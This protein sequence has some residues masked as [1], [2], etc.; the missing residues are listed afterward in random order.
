[1]RAENSAGQIETNKNSFSQ[2]NLM[3]RQYVILAIGAFLLFGIFFF[4]KQPDF[5]GFI[6]AQGGNVT[7]VNIYSYPDVPWK[8]LHGLMSTIGVL[9]VY[10]QETDPAIRLENIGLSPCT[11]SELYST[12]LSTVNWALVEPA[13]PSDVDLFLG[14]ANTS[15]YSGTAIFTNLSAFNVTNRG[16]LLYSTRTVSQSGVYDLGILKQG[17]TL[18]FVSH[19]DTGLA[20]DGTPTDYQLMLPTPSGLNFTYFLFDDPWDRTQCNISTAGNSGPQFSGLGNIDTYIG[21]ET[22]GTFYATDADLDALELV[23]EPDMNLGTYMWYNTVLGRYVIYYNFT[24]NPEGLFSVNFVLSDGISQTWQNIEVDVGYCGNMDSGGDPKCESRFEDCE[25]CPRDC[26]L[27]RDNRES[28]ALIPDQLFCIGQEI[29]FT[30]YERYKPDICHESTYQ[31]VGICEKLGGVNVDILVLNRGRWKYL[32]SKTTAS[33]G[34]FTF[35]P[36]FTR[37]Y[38]MI[39]NRAGHYPFFLYLDGLDCPIKEIPAVPPTGSIVKNISETPRIETP[40]PADRFI[41]S[42]P[43]LILYNLVLVGVTVFILRYLHK[44]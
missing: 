24:G 14:V 22:S 16:Y 28:F 37:E 18:I 15:I 26:G 17:G 9:S 27:C 10:L 29:T 39:A 42:V 20:Y 43:L 1:M 8:G 21:R 30:A 32:E 19:P 23:I 4:L 41:V 13:L 33:D 25:T 2:C 36:D 44:K 31:G 35:S 40:A 3:R 34:T 12:T 11:G 38:K 6:T 5:I 7:R